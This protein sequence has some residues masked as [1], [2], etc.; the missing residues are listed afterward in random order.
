MKQHCRSHP[1]AE[2]PAGTLCAGRERAGAHPRAAAD[3]GGQLLGVLHRGRGCRVGGP[4]AVQCIRPCAPSA[5][6]EVKGVFA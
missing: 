2:H 3:A 4:C 6:N 1:V 5:E